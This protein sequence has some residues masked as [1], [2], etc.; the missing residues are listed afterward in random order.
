MQDDYQP[1][2]GQ[3]RFTSHFPEHKTILGGTDSAYVRKLPPTFPSL[4]SEIV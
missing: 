3:A 4:K 1:K 2:K